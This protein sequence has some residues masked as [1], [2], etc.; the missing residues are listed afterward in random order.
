M[1][2]RSFISGFSR[3]SKNIISCIIVI[4]LLVIA[5]IKCTS[6]FEIKTATIKYTPFYEAKTNY[7]VIFLGSSHMYNTIYPMELWKDYGISSFNW[8]YSNCTAA[9][10]YYLLRD[11][12][13]YTSPKLVVID[14]YGIAEFGHW[15]KYSADA[16]GQ[17]HV[18]FDRMPFSMEKIHAAR[19]AFEAY[20]GKS[21]FIWN[22]A[23]YHNRWNALNKDDF[24]YELSPEKGASIC[25]G[26]LGRT[27]YS[28]IPDG[29]KSD[30]LYGFNFDAYL[31]M[32]EFCNEQGIQV[33]CVYTPCAAQEFNQ[34]VANTIGDKVEAYPNCKYANMLNE[35]ILNFDT[36]FIAD[37]DH[38]NYSGGTKTTAWMGRYLRDNYE[39]D[40]YSDNENWISD[41][42]DYREFK[43]SLMSEQESLPLYLPHLV[44]DDFTAEAVI[45]DKRVLEF[46][47]INLLFDNAGIEPRLQET[48]GEVCAKLTIRSAE[49]N[50][51]VEK[52]EFKWKDPGN[53]EMFDIVKIK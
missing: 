5:L 31:K 15:T 7:D 36:D 53:P 42:E 6:L 8:G 37:N 19:D 20:S 21:D 49:T 1:K 9:V 40:D 51:I 14:A 3:K 4:S 24:E 47:Q 43:A 41:Y 12:V 27:S 25:S 50:E 13:K 45:Y 28:K 22:F 17:Y 16:I 30:E 52:A 44:D 29:L 2:Q 18:Q 39:L 33:L 32:I 46:E 35:G 23:L 26:S 34:R 38:L 10:E 11:L 48:D